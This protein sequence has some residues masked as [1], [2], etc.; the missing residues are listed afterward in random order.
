MIGDALRAFAAVFPAE[1]PDKTMVA[2]IVLVARYRHPL[3]VWCGAALAFTVHVIVAVAA[4]RL[5][6]LLPDV[7]VKAMVSVLFAIG[8][9]VLWRAAA[10]AG[11][12]DDAAVVERASTRA[13]I[14]G[15]FGVI[16]LAE[17]GDLT[18]LA[19]ASLAAT[20]E[21][22]AAVGVGALGALWAVAGIAVTAGRQ[23]VAR[24]SLRTLHRTAALVFAG[25]AVLTVAELIRG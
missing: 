14:A 12:A 19:T 22:P 20:S 5:V 7:A 25:L 18:Q 24:V 1:L 8:A 16:A 13:A 3:A 15:S 9:V 17:W 2:S 4:G 21:H 23:L 11:D 10:G 6:S